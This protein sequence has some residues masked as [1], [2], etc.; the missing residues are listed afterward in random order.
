MAFLVIAYPDINQID[1]DWIQSIRKDYDPKYFNV[2]NPHV[3]LVFST[4]KLSLEDF[5]RLIQN[6]LSSINSFE[7]I[8]DSMK[9]VEDDSKEFFHVFLVPSKGYN[10]INKIHDVLYE[11]DLASELRLDIPFIP[12][13]GIGT[14]KESEMTELIH[15][16][17]NQ[18]PVIEGHIS[19]VSIVEY[20]GSK[21]KDLS[22]IT[23]SNDK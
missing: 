4:N 19:K 21:V 12:H 11:D 2:V 7:I 23:L 14:G 10:E 1:F 15:N 16:L 6:K 13:L 18:K 20:D 5:T 8:F 9:L 17:E 22:E 3:T